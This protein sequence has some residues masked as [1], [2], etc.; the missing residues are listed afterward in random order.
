MFVFLASF[1]SCSIYIRNEEKSFITWMRSN[2][3]FYTGDEYFIR[4]GI[5]I[6]NARYV[7]EHNSAQKTFRIGL[8]RFAASTPAEYKSLLV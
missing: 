1:V 7:R 4:L 2:N 5:F 6:T 8:N 3:Q